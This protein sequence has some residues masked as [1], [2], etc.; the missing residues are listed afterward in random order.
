VIAAARDAMAA[1]VRLGEIAAAEQAGQDRPATSSAK[2]FGARSSAPGLSSVDQTILTAAEREG[3]KSPEAN[4]RDI[5]GE[6]GHPGSEAPSQRTGTVTNGL[7]PWGAPDIL[8]VVGQA[9]GGGFLPGA[10]VGPMQSL[11]GG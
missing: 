9:W 6:P 3:S 1:R 5:A 4:T 10:R 7:T 2:I 8:T 11:S